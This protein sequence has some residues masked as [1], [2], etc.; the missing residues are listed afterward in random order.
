MDLSSLIPPWVKI[1]I[2]VALV[3][4]VVTVV[5]QWRA[6][7]M[8]VAYDRVFKK[9]V[10]AQLAEQ[11]NR[12]K[13]LLAVETS[14]REELEKQIANQQKIEEDLKKLAEEFRK[15]NF[16]NVPLDPGVKFTLDQ[17]LR[18]EAQRKA[19]P[20]PTSSGNPTLDQWKKAHP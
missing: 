7:I 18:A 1:A 10:T 16:K 19:A 3:T 8:E 13:E 2:A 14:K 20:A 15:Q 6:D 11:E 12:F 9:Q 17:I 5:Y 4:V